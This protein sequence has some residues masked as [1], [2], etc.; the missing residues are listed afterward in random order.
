MLLH[1]QRGG[2]FGAK[3]WPPVSEDEILML[4]ASVDGN[5]I[6]RTGSEG[7]FLLGT[8]F[9]LLLTANSNY[10][11]FLFIELFILSQ[12]LATRFCSFLVRAAFF[13]TFLPPIFSMERSTF[14]P[15]T[16]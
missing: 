13:F 16:R 15:P 5:L 10:H 14:D 9:L 8:I 1:Y 12:L 6:E 7:L 4:L 2:Q 3:M 11:F